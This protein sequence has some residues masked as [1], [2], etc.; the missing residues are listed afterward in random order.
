MTSAALKLHS[1]ILE[2]VSD[3]GATKLQLVVPPTT[4][5]EQMQPGDSVSPDKKLYELLSPTTFK[6]RSIGQQ[7]SS[8]RLA[9]DTVVWC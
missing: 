6:A 2:E 1:Q 8:K 3:E 4:L 9:T 5:Q 7:R